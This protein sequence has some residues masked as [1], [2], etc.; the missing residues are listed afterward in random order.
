MDG[1]SGE[2]VFYSKEFEAFRNIYLHYKKLGSIINL[3]YLDFDII[4]QNIT[5]PKRFWDQTGVLRDVIGSNW[6]QCNDGIKD[7]G[8]SFRYLCTSYQTAREKLEKGYGNSL[9]CKKVIAK[10]LLCKIS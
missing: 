2:E 10:K 9:D 3:G 6:N 5:F 7:F 4:F 1:I 8:D